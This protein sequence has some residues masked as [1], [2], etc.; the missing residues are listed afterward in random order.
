MLYYTHSTECVQSCKARVAQLVDAPPREGGYS[1]GSN[2]TP[3]TKDLLLSTRRAARPYKARRPVRW[4]GT[5]GFETLGE[6]QD[7]DGEVLR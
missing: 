7:H 2:P 1:V 4:A 5:A 3:G 6:Y